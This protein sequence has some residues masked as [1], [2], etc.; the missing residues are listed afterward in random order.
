MPTGRTY[1][2]T[3]AVNGKIYAIGGL[4]TSGNHVSQM[5]EYD[6]ATNTWTTKADMPTARSGLATSAVNGKIYAIGGWVGG[7][8]TLSTVEEYDT[9]FILVDFNGDGRVDFK[10]YAIFAQSAYD[11]G[12]L[13]AKTLSVLVANWLTAWTIPPLPGPVSNPG[14]ANDATD[15]DLNAELS[16]MAGVYATSYDVSFGTSSPPPFIGNQTAATFDPGTMV[17]SSTYYWRIDSVNIWGTATGPVWSFTTIYS[18]LQASNPNPTDGA[19]GVDIDADL[20]WTAGVGATSHDV[21]FGTS[22]PPP[23]QLNQTTA[24]FNPG[25][26]A[27]G[28]TYYWRIDETGAYGTTTGMAWSFTNMMSPPPF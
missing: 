23:F 7:G 25:T 5:E 26:M 17:Y 19:L 27:Y 3:S 14:P 6:P 21:Y 10:D 11:D 24:T 8:T 4:T 15:V 13:D 12:K 22:N 20:S 28:T 16:W 9:G 18:D 1:L 2:S